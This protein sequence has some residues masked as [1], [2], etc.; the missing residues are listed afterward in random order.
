MPTK[1]MPEGGARSEPKFL[2]PVELRY[3]LKK[4]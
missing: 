4:M 1:F 2:P 3:A